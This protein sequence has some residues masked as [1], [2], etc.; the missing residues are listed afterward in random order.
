MFKGLFGKN[1][2]ESGRNKTGF[3]KV[4]GKKLIE[5]DER[6]GIGSINDT[7]EYLGFHTTQ[8]HTVNTFDSPTIEVIG[9]KI[10]TKQP[11]F[12]WA[13]E[14]NTRLD[15][16]NLSRELKNTDWDF[17]YSSHTIEDILTE[18]IEAQSLTFEY[19][20]SVLE[21]HKESDTLFN[22]PS[23]GLYLNFNNGYL[24]S[25]TSSDW[26]NT[27]SKWLKGV[28]E[29]LFENMLSEAM[30]YHRNEIEAMEE[31]NLVCEALQGIPHAMQ[32]EFIEMHRKP[33][34]NIN[35]FNLLA[36]HYNNFQGEP[37]KID[38]FQ[39]VNKGRYVKLN[40]QTFEVDNF[41]YQF[42]SEGQ[43][44]GSTGK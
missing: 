33:N 38:D 17:E 5:L 10:F 28:N 8:I 42:D 32:N 35:F 6:L 20:S 24:E 14:K 40:D 11:V 37:I 12:V 13:K 2:N 4:D 27:A 19:L 36:A 15:F 31:V 16:K 39:I 44:T 26:A 1:S 23:I 29:R 41:I 34:G 9:V 30:R 21:L 18:G 43:L 22:A 7:I 25:Y 3:Y